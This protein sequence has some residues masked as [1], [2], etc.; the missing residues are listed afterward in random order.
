[1]TLYFIWDL[2]TPP[3][4]TSL[5]QCL[6]PHTPMDVSVPSG[7]KCTIDENLLCGLKTAGLQINE[8]L[9]YGTSPGLQVMYQCYIHIHKIQAQVAV[10]IAE[11]KW[12]A[13]AGKYPNK[14]EMIGLC[15]AKATWHNSCAKLFPTAE[16]YEDMLAWL[17]GDPNSKSD[18]ELWGVTKLKYTLV[19]L[20]EW[21]KKQ[22]GKKVVKSMTKSASKSANGAKEKEK[23]Q[24]SGSGVR[25]GDPTELMQKE[26]VTEQVDNKKRSHQK[27]KVSASG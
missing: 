11:H 26:V 27:K 8:S 3:P 21:L 17:E 20:E 9:C 6:T 19:G 22:K 25:K 23:K 12:P 4:L 13:D 1:M 18:L 2:L 14:T 10:M 5:V 7:A 24:R 15:V 16:G